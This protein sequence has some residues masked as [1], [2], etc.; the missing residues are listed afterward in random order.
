MKM[1]PCSKSNRRKIIVIVTFS[2]LIAVFIVITTQNIANSD[3][4]DDAHSQEYYTDGECNYN[5]THV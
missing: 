2:I 4:V 1:M 5:V 3:N